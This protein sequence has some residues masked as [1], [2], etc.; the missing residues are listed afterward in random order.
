M[1]S[2]A[3]TASRSRLSCN[4]QA[5]RAFPLA[6]A[7][8]DV[9]KRASQFSKASLSLAACGNTTTSQNVALKD[10]LPGFVVAERGGVVR[11]AEL[12]SQDYLYL[13]P[14]RAA[15]RRDAFAAKIA[16]FHDFVLVTAAVT[17]RGAPSGL[18][19]QSRQFGIEPAPIALS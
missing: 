17:I 7:N 10:L 9:S 4:G 6:S 5:L 8:P 2:A 14:L 3:A 11:I 1:A 13:R 12:Q 19:R 15:D 18:G 16:T